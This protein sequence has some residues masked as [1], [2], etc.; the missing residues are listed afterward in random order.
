MS[1]ADGPTE[2][3]GTWPAPCHYR[4]LSQGGRLLDGAIEYGV[5]KA[6]KV[7]DVQTGLDR[8]LHL[9]DRG[10]GQQHGTRKAV[11]CLI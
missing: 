7:G 4:L 2:L 8:I 10:S 3:G 1:A 11:K 6:G 9:R 5:R